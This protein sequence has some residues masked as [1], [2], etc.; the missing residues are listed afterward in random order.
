MNGLLIA[1]LAYAALLAALGLF[2]S[3]GVRGSGDFFVAR[4][5]LGPGL[6]F[7]TFLAANLGAGTTVGAAELG[8]RIGLG[9]WWWVGSAGIGSLVLAFV[10]GPKIYRLAER[11]NLYTVGDY[12][13]LRYSRA[14]KLTAAGLLWI[15]SLAILA[16]QLIA[17]GLV[18]E[19][20]AGLPRA[21]GCVL[22]GVIVTA[23]FTAG[24]LFGSA[25]IN[26]L[27]VGVK[28]AGFLIAVPWA[29]GSAGGWESLLERTAEAAGPEYASITGVGFNGIVRYAA[30][31]I[32]S[33]IVS[34]GLIQKLFGAKDQRTV[35]WGVGTQG[36]VLL[37]YSFLPVA[38]GMVAYARWPALEDPGLALPKLLAEAMPPLLGG[39][40]LA[41]IFS[42]EISSA[43]AVLFMMSTAA[44]RDLGPVLLGGA[45]DDRR[46]LRLARASAIAAGAAGVGIALW[47]DSIISALVVFYS[48]LTVTLFAPL[49]AG[50]FWSRPRA[51]SAL[52]G[53]AAGV[54]VTVAVHA[55]TGGDGWGALTPTV[56]GIGVGAVF[57]VLFALRSREA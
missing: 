33:F 56:A 5:R 4:R 25:W 27:Q 47:L 45:P 55:V 32:P 15:G 29:L 23:Y 54:P 46:L 17:M 22:G 42:A 48:L 39:L 6:L 3:R 52:A 20:V 16:G 57:Y 21:W 8:Y 7:G 24:G 12:L 11:H 10:V 28:A 36:G 2:L 53:I 38:L 49:L 50:L 51:G 9:A 19:A 26:L 14:V 35:R 30:V 18:L 44:A 13:E 31:L 43:D 41:A 40:M 34:P 37:L 1:I